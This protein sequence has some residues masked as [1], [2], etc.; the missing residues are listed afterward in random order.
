[1]VDAG[2]EP[3]RPRAG[4]DYRGADDLLW[5]RLHLAQSRTDRARPIAKRRPNVKTNILATSLLLGLGLSAVSAGQPDP[6]FYGVWVGVETYG[7]RFYI[8]GAGPTVKMAAEIGIGDSGTIFAV[9]QGLGEGRYEVS[10][11]WGKN[12]LELEVRS[13]PSLFG[14]TGTYCGRTHCK[15][16]LSTDGTTLT[17]TTFVALPGGG[18]QATITGTFHRK[19]KTLRG[20]KR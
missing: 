18:T 5:V 20:K 2:L 8:Q 6:R 17:E 15:L 10:P 19:E 11:S 13:G 16:A 7:G 14:N 1:M 4:V 3:S 9:G 12:T